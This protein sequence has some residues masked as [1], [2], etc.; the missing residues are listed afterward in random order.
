MSLQLSIQASIASIEMKRPFSASLQ[1][2]VIASR[3]LRPSTLA[4]YGRAR[5]AALR[6]FI[7]LRASV[8]ECF[9][10]RIVETG[11]VGACCHGAQS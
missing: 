10:E 9:L 5:R 11:W 2:N 7:K 1:R 4:R 8:F 3:L 6:A